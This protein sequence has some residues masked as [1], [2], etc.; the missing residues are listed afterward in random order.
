MTAHR[1]TRRRML[2]GTGAALLGAG[3]L[4]A[5]AGQAS[6]DATALD[7]SRA[8]ALTVLLAALAYGP[9]PELDTARY[10]DDFDAYYAEAHAPFRRYVDD[11]L[12]ALGAETA[13]MLAAPDEAAALMQS[14]AAEPGRQ[15]LASR[16]LELGSLTFQEDELKTAGLTLVTGGTS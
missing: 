4:G 7:V 15:L 1:M 12:D 11:G 5:A 9:A 6:A 13:F 16:A 14:W 2:Q 3:L 10:A 8:A